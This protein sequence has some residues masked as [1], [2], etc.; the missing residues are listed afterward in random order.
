M[1][2]KALGPTSKCWSVGI[3]QRRSVLAGER[4]ELSVWRGK[5]VWNDEGVLSFFSHFLDRCCCLPWVDSMDRGGRGWRH[6]KSSPIL[7][8]SFFLD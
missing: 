3:C 6:V 8:N 4:A 2:A 7:L 1:S 5:K